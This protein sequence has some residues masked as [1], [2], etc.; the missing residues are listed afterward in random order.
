MEGEYDEIIRA[1]RVIAMLDVPRAYGRQIR[2]FEF[3]HV[4][5]QEAIDQFSALLR[6]DGLAVTSGG[7]VSFVPMGRINSVV[8]YAT[9]LKVINRL[10]YWAEKI[11]IPMAGDEKQ[12][13]VY[14]RP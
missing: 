6:E 8:A 3:A 2:I 11:D 7:D 12:Y 4:S 10:T 9:N 13:Y 14:R 1:I 5:P